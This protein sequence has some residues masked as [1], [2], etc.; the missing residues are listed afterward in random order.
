MIDEQQPLSLVV[1]GKYKIINKLGEGSFGKIFLGE[2]IYT[3]EKIAIKIEFSSESSVLRNEAKI[4]KY[5]DKCD[6]IPKMRTFGIEGKFNYMVIDLL[7]ESL[8]SL[9]VRYGGKV[10][11]DKVVEIGIQMINNIERLHKLGIIHR[12]IKP[13]NFLFN[14]ENTSLKIID[15]GLARRYLNEKGEH[16]KEEH[17]RKLTGTARYVSI[18]VHKGIT[19]SRRD[20]M[21]SIIYILIYLL[22]GELPWQNV[23]KKGR[24]ENIMKNKQSLE[25]K[26]EYKEMEEVMNYTRKLGYAEK[27]KYENCKEVLKSLKEKK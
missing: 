20:D 11:I 5:L 23:K 2:N 21:E 14:V 17:G 10:D 6:G 16:I 15:F 25:F 24:N 27:P 26:K 22:N 12:D 3:G 13:E 9:R 1:E 19:P 18:N 4:Y 7:G 8:E